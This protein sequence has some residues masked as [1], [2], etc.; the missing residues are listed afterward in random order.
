MERD[1]CAQGSGEVLI[2]LGDQ[3]PVLASKGYNRIDSRTYTCLSTQ[4]YV[5]IFIYNMEVCV[6]KEYMYTC[7]YAPLSVAILFL[8]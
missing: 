7:I 2:E 8:D 3:I 5:E 4:S 6:E 1:C